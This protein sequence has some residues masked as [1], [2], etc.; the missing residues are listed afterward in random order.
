MDVTHH[1]WAS[2]T[3]LTPKGAVASVSP[4]PCTSTDPVPQ[5]THPSSTYTHPFT[6]PAPNSHCLLTG[7][8]PAPR[9]A[10]VTP[11][12]PELDPSPSVRSI[13]SP[14]MESEWLEGPRLSRPIEQQLDLEEQPGAL[15][16]QGLGASRFQKDFSPSPLHSP[17]QGQCWCLHVPQS[18]N[19]SQQ[20]LCVPCAHTMIVPPPH[21]L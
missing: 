14:C 5:Q 17:V 19:L 13:C 9:Q 11:V 10:F 12:C 21:G 20:T 2:L 15:Q 7:T 1:S 3:N 18:G 16:I 6:D 8:F 4:L